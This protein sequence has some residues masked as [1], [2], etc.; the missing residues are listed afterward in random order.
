MGKK[1]KK[2]HINYSEVRLAYIFQSVRIYDL[3]SG[4]VSS[5]NFCKAIVSKGTEG[6]GHR[7]WSQNL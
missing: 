3:E 4:L 5:L 6:L 7:L 2:D 1:K